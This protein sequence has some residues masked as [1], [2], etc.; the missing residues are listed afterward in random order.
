[1]SCHNDEKLDKLL[2]K[3]VEIIFFDGSIDRGILCDRETA[4]KQVGHILCNTP[5]FIVNPSG[6]TFG[7]YKTHVKKLKG[8]T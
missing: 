2:N 6:Y 3:Q 8:V 7:F 4:Q 1:M 5:Y